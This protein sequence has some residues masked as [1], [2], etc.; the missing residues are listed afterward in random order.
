MRARSFFVRGALAVSAASIL[1]HF[2][3][4][5]QRALQTDEWF[6]KER[7][8]DIRTELETKEDANDVDALWRLAR[9]LRFL[10]KEENRSSDERKS[11]AEKAVEYSRR[12]V[13]LDS[14]HA[15]AWKWLGI[16]LSALGD[17]LGT[18]QALRN[19]PEIRNCWEMS[20][21]L[22]KSATTANLLG[23]WCFYFATMSTSTYYA[24]KIIFGTPPSSTVEE[25]L[26]YFTLAESLEPGFY[27]TNRWQIAQCY[28][29]LNQMQEFR[30]FR[31]LALEMPSLDL[32][33][34]IAHSEAQSY[35]RY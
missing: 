1:P 7:Y 14:E 23:S 17:H 15:A 2:A 31:D 12:A 16:S 9:A 22:D 6:Q 18:K 24:A 27:K 25:A 28:Y 13:Q 21:K 20:L 29:H 35:L 33:D 3:L 8:L 5:R 4:E 32:D 30:I 10:S 26:A 19:A 34:R 11:A